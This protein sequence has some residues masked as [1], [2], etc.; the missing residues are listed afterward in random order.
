MRRANCRWVPTALR[1]PAWELAELLE[2]PLAA[3]PPP[4][5]RLAPK[6]MLLGW[7]RQAQRT[8]MLLLLA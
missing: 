2:A 6:L 5:G 4:Q 7:V 8:P 3:D 1:R